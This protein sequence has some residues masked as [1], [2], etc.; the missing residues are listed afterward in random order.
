MS[1]ALNLLVKPTINTQEEDKKAYTN[2]RVTTVTTPEGTTNYSYACQSNV[3]NITKPSASSGTDERVDFTYDGTLL[4]TLRQSGILN[5]TLSYSYNNNFRLSSFTYADKTENYSYDLDGLLTQSGDYSIT[6]NA[7]NGLVEQVSNGLFNL[8]YRY[9]KFGEVKRAKDNLF[10]YRV[11]R[12]KGRIASKRE[13]L[14]VKVPKKRKGFR[15]KKKI[16]FYYY[17]YDNRDR[18]IEVRKGKAKRLVE[19]YSYDSN[20]NRA[21]ATVNGTTV[22]AS[23]TLDDNLVVYGQNTYT[24][25][26]D[27]YL[28][29]KVTP[30]GTTTY[31]YGTLG[32]L[33]E[34]V[35]PTK[36][37]T[38]LVPQLQ[39]WNAYQ[40]PNNKANLM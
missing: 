13:V 35:T 16:S 26:E 20:G 29:E 36:T 28:Q 5:Q 19:S 34:V 22:T 38:L 39:L 14:T 6:R 15:K 2:G 7:Q 8:S 12:A 37:I 32:E 17:T 27:G 21:S 9:N 25:D 24:Y 40:T 30:E 33:K 3:A 18:L 10:I 11:K 23:Y 1:V 31:T 4:T